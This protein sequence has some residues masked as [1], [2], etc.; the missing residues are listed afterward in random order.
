MVDGPCSRV[1]QVN[2][3]VKKSGREIIWNIDQD[4]NLV[5]FAL[6]PPKT[7]LSEDT[8]PSSDDEPSFEQSSSNKRARPKNSF[9]PPSSQSTTNPPSSPSKNADNEIFFELSKKRRVTVRKW[10]AGILVDIREYWGDE[11]D[12][13]P[14]KKGISLTIDQWNTLK[15]LVPDI[16]DAITRLPK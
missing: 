9:Q 6:M 3:G 10:R 2:W 12:L 7:K 15:D 11:G 4:V 13:K 8:I 5:I 16:D 14:G 1:Y